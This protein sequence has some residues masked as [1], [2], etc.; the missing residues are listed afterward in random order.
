MKFKDGV[1]TLQLDI[2][3]DIAQKVS[4]RHSH[5]S[6][7]GY[8]T[9]NFI[10]NFACTNRKCT[11]N[12]KC[13]PWR[14]ARQSSCLWLNKAILF[15]ANEPVW[16]ADKP[17]PASWWFRRRRRRNWEPGQDESDEWGTSAPW[18]CPTLPG[19]PSQTPEPHLV[20]WDNE[21]QKSISRNKTMTAGTEN[22]F[23]NCLLMKKTHLLK[24]MQ[25]ANVK[26]CVHVFVFKIQSMM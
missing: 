14:D 19:R 5:G 24:N 11:A 12:H 1:H 25:D 6:T 26:H 4:W 17:F 16:P 18:Q 15:R 22:T 20:I 23:W 13:G 21:Q 8:P 3:Q 10:K 2:P 9:W 7:P